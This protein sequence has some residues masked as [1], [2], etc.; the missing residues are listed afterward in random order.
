MPPPEMPL[1]KWD[2]G[3]YDCKH[4]YTD[5]GCRIR[6]VWVGERRFR[7]V[8]RMWVGRTGKLTLFSGRTRPGRCARRRRSVSDVARA[9]ARHRWLGSERQRPNCR[10]GPNAMLS[11]HRHRIRQNLLAP[12]RVCDRL[13]V[14]AGPCDVGRRARGLRGVLTLGW[15]AI[16]G[17][18]IS[19]FDEA[20]WPRRPKI[21]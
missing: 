12:A 11:D 5:I 18:G 4:D 16:R 14:S 8:Y 9:E 15:N 6:H 2:D 20:V 19:P 13:A 7:E 1:P 17:L 3:L 21:V 10:Q